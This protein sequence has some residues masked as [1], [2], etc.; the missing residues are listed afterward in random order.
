MMAISNFLIQNKPRY[1]KACLTGRIQ[2]YPLLEVT[3]FEQLPY[4]RCLNNLYYAQTK[5]KTHYAR[6]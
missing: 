2:F 3:L 1:G 6:L 5:F 4:P